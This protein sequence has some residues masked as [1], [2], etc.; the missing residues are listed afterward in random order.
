[1]RRKRLRDFE[2][3]N[4]TCHEVA[5][6]RSW[7]YIS[8][9]PFGDESELLARLEL[10]VSQCTSA[11]VW[12]HF[13]NDVALLQTKATGQLRPPTTYHWIGNPPYLSFIARLPETITTTDQLLRSMDRIAECGIP[14]RPRRRSHRRGML[15]RW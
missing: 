10:R 3:R 15:F 9:H 1:M 8:V 2:G 11:D 13:G 4:R 5:E 12:W 6:Y 7:R 14:R